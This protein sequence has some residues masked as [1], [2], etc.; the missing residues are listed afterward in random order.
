MKRVLG[1]RAGP[2][3]LLLPADAA[4]YM[5]AAEAADRF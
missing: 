2:H 5:K 1:V 4:A 3:G